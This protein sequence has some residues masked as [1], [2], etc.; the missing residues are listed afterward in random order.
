MEGEKRGELSGRQHGTPYA[1]SMDGL[2]AGHRAGE[3]IQRL[4]FLD[5][6]IALL[7]GCMDADEEDIPYPDCLF[8]GFCW[9]GAWVQSAYTKS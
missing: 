6:L 5:A 7:H 2:V 1:Y 3:V 8:V 4:L 9:L